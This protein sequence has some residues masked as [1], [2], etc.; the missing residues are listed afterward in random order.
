MQDSSE[1]LARLYA[2]LDPLARH[3]RSA[4]CTLLMFSFFF[5]GTLEGLFGLMAACCVLCCAAPGS[6]GVAHASRCAKICAV[7]TATLALLHLLAISTFAVAVLPTMPAAVAQTCTAH[8]REMDSLTHSAH[9][10]GKLPAPEKFGLSDV[11]LT[12]KVFAEGGL[13]VK[14]NQPVPPKMKELVSEEPMLA[15][16]SYSVAAAKLVAGGSVRVSRHLEQLVAVVTRTT[17]QPAPLSAH[18][19]KVARFFA[20]FAPLALLMAGLVEFCLFLSAMTLAR[21]ATA[22][23]HTARS[24][25]ANGI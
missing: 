3:V 14:E 13:P 18:C 20:D 21:R 17:F 8:E 4:A 6:L 22:L 7:C 19:A 10:A 11:F 1:G 9:P 12:G 24:M 16:G 23:V 15:D 2:D 25:G 5:C